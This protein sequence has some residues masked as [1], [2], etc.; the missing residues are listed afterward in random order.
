[1]GRTM[2]EHSAFD[3]HWDERFKGLSEDWKVIELVLP[4]GWQEAARLTGALRRARGFRDAASLLRVMLIHLVDGCSLRE[5]AFRARAAG[6]TEVSD[7]ALL[8]RLRG[9]GEWF[10]WMV[11]RMSRRLSPTTPNVGRRVLL[12]DTSVV[13]ELGAKGST[14]Q[15]QYLIDLSTLACEQLQIMTLPGEGE[16]LTRFEVQANDILLVGRALALYNGV[17][18]VIERGGDLIVRPNIVSVLLEDEEGKEIALLSKLR[19]LAVGEARDLTAFMPGDQGSIALRVCAVKKS[20]QQMRKA[21]D[22][23]REIASR[24]QVNLQPGTLEA[25]GYVVVLTTLTQV[26]AQRILELYR[27]CWQ[28][29]LAF[30]RLKSLLQLGHLKRADQAGAKAWLQ[31]KLFVAT[32]IE[33]LVAVGERFSPWGY[34]LYVDL[35]ARLLS[36]PTGDD[37]CPP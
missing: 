7:V 33:S 23:V 11:E 21:Q 14:W 19:E 20:A 1:M 24:S 4:E 35:G 6:L 12:A 36:A 31:G 10:R 25:A 27:L 17:R 26:S 30:R 34:F 2:G 5:T 28:T 9:C 3:L 22:K 29:E 15:I 37:A 13:R 16:S 32:L 18:Y 8:E